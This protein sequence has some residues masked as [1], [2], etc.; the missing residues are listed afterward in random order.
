MTKI[1]F[2]KDPR[3]LVRSADALLVIAPAARFRSGRWRD[4]LGAELGGLAKRL[5]TRT[6]AGI[7]GEVASTLGSGKLEVLHVGVLPDSVSRYNSA[8]RADSIST[9]VRAAKIGNATKPAVL[10]V[11]DRDSHLTAACNAVH[12]PGMTA[13]ARAPRTKSNSTIFNWPALAAL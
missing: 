2:Q 3:A 4:A 8:A 9:V 11:L 13:S 7:R 1:D 12:P 5:G 6:E 10:L